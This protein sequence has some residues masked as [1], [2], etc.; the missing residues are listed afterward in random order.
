M[1]VNI[2][3]KKK[4]ARVPSQVPVP[5]WHWDARRKDGP[6]SSGP[7]ANKPLRSPDVPFAPLSKPMCLSTTVNLVLRPV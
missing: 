1:G 4:F 3:K 2:K 7:L 5:A 6:G